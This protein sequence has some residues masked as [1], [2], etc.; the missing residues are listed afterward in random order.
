M[1]TLV[2]LGWVG[3]AISA[4]V[5]GFWRLPISAS[6]Y[7]AAIIGLALSGANLDSFE[8]YV[9]AA[10]TLFLAAAMALKGVWARRLVLAGLA[11]SLAVA[12]FLS[13][14]NVLVP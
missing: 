10:P 12:A 1:S 5:I 4:L 3:L 2:H 11:A 6:I 7:S 8:R 13:F 9:M 14:C